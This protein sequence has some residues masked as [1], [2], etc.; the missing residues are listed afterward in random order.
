[1]EPKEDPGKKKNSYKKWLILT[2]VAFQMGI[3]IYLSAYLGKWL[4]AKYSDGEKIYTPFLVI[5]GVFLAIFGVLKQL[6]KI[7]E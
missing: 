1:M 4:D 5:I 2:G 7:N 3:T 6:K